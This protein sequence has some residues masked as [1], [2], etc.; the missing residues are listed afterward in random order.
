MSTRKGLTIAGVAV[1][2]AALL[3]G[4]A[5]TYAS[6]TDTTSSETTAITA[7]TLSAG[8]TQEG[9][10]A[11]EID[12]DPG[13]GVYPEDESQGMIPGAQGQQWSYTLENDASSDVVADAVLLLR[14]WP[15]DANEY[16]AF[17]P[18]LRATIQVD[19]Q[20]PIEVPTESFTESGFAFDLD[21]GTR[22]QPGETVGAT[23]TIY[24]PA[25]VDSP[26]GGTTNVGF[27][28]RDLRSA[29]T[30]GHPVLTMENSVYL[31]QAG[32]P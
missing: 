12:G 1:V 32:A 19:G 4:G 16:G 24:M 31:H 18:Y 21:L 15:S 26:D 6:W 25:T 7:G 13:P 23:L 10:T 17:R 5:S 20:E 14:G 2:A 22:L 28:L 30:A 8:L 11:V 3:L 29:D 9:P 27:A